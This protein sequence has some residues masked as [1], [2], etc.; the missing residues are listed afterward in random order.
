MFQALSTLYSVRGNVL[1]VSGYQSW[2]AWSHIWYHQNN[3]FK[4]GI[5]KKAP[6]FIG[7]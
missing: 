1:V 2:T 4:R 3:T 5:T 6:A 7:N